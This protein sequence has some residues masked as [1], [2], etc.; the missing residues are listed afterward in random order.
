MNKNYI[1]FFYDKEDNYTAR[2]H[3]DG[4]VC[5]IKDKNNLK[6]L[7]ELLA[8]KKIYLYNQAGKV[9]DVDDVIKDFDKYMIMLKRMKKVTKP[10]KVINKITSNMKLSKKNQLIGKTIVAGSLA[11]AIG[12]TTVGI[13]NANKDDDKNNVVPQETIVYVE[14]TS[15]TISIEEDTHH[16]DISLE[17]PDENVEELSQMMI[18][19]DSNMIVDEFH[20]SYEDRSN[21][22]TLDRARRYEDIFE[23]YAKMYG[24]DKELLIAIGAQE[25]FG[26]HYENIHSGGSTGIMKIEDINLGSTIKAYNFE[27]GKID[28][29]YLTREA[30]EDLDTNIQAGAIITRNKVDA[31]HNNIPLFLQSYNYGNGNMSKVLNMCAEHE[32]MT[33]EE[34]IANPTY[35]GWMQYRSRA[36]EKGDPEYLERILSYLPSGYE[37]NILDRNGNPISM[38]VINDNVKTN[39]M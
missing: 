28:S 19:N 4:K 2:I 37:I 22:Y 20:F 16:E 15:P 14:E 18:E 12:L 5:T 13:V 25:N 9:E 23:K 39:Q 1:E 6:V 26:N 17:E 34:I 32:N 11:A 33:K 10:L 27:T 29:L 3:K 31:F 35:S 21:L 36:V 8:K 30:L 7:K 38:K 24:L